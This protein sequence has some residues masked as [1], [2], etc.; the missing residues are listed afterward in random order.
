[1]VATVGSVIIDDLNVE[2]VSGLES[3]AESPLVVDPNAVGVPT[4]A[5]ERLEAVSGRDAQEVQRSGRIKL[6]QLALRHPFEG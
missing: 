4:V 3:E 1:M 6:R 2:G 5:L